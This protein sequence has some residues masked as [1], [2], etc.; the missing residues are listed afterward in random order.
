MAIAEKVMN[1]APGLVST[2]P[3]QGPQG[4]IFAAP[5]LEAPRTMSHF[6][7]Q[8]AVNSA[9]LPF[10]SRQDPVRAADLQLT[11]AVPPPTAQHPVTPAS[12]PAQDLPAQIEQLRN[13]IFGIAMNTSALNDRLDRMEQRLPQAGQSAQAGIA[14]L[15]GEIETWLENHLNAAVEHCMNQIINRTQSAANRPVN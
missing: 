13:D 6:G 15:R 10:A 3:L 12:V 4:S 9:G 2:E 7:P 5:A 8:G 14:A 11:A 1:H